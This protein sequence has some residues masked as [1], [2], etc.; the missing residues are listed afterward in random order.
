[1]PARK[2]SRLCTACGERGAKY[3]GRLEHK[4]ESYFL[5]YFHTKQ[6]RREARD[7]KRR[8]LRGPTLPDSYTVAAWAGRYLDEYGRKHKRSSLTTATAS[9][10]PFLRTFGHR[11]LGSIERIEAKDWTRDARP[12]WLPQVVALHSHAIDERVIDYNPFIGLSGSSRGRADTA[13]PT[14]DEL[15]ALLSACDALGDYAEQMRA[16]VIVGAYTGMRPGELFELRWSDIDLAHHRVTV[17][18][19]IY[20]GVVDTPKN[21]RPKTI[22]LPPAARDA[23]MRQPTRA[24]E[25]VFLSQRGRQL[26]QRTLWGYW[27]KVK[28]A[29]GLDFDFYLATKHYGVCKLYAAGLSPRAIAAQMG[30]SE[31]GVTDLLRTY[32]HADV[33]ALAEVDALY[34]ERPDEWRDAARREVAE[35]STCPATAHVAQMSDAELDAYDEQIARVNLT[36]WREAGMGEAEIERE[37][38]IFAPNVQDAYRRITEAESD[39]QP[40]RGAS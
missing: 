33:V 38:G 13:P 27:E 5:G 29:A 31:A 20:R 25:L 36:S 21:G 7:A 40:R 1:M 2:P 22:A 10:Q 37:F 39:A 12:S 8:E 35:G 26:S 17:S 14:V 34:G 15:S 23:L 19:R 4:G 9:L 24:G 3:L 30:W 11:T 18:R 6:E 32:G 28:A 16:L